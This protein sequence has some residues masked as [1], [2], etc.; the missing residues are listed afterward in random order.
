VR[1]LANGDKISVSIAG[2]QT[3]HCRF[4]GATGDLLFCDAR[5]AWSGD[6]SYQFDRN[7]VKE[8]RLDHQVRNRRVLTGIAAVAGGV[9]AGLRASSPVDTRAGVF[10][11]L[12]GAGAFALIT[13]PICAGVALFIPGSLIYR[14]PRPQNRP[15]R[16]AEP[17]KPAPS[18]VPG[19]TIAS[20]STRYPAFVEQE[21]ASGLFR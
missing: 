21:S 12:A 19:P 6:R 13:Y 5:Y 11:G 20:E 15:A 7:Q 8:V 14:Q 4:A 10:E 16:S 2:R 3:L 17:A 9:F 18:P 1:D